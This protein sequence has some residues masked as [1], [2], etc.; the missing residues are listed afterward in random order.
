MAS[1]ARGV[2]GA[3]LASAALCTP[4]AGFSAV[5]VSTSPKQAVGVAEREGAKEQ[6]EI[7]AGPIAAAGVTYAV[8]TFAAVAMKKLAHRPKTAARVLNK[9]IQVIEWQVDPKTPVPGSEKAC[10]AMVGADVETEGVWDPLGFS[11]LYDR[12]FDFNMVMTYPHVQW[13]RESEIKHGR[14]CMLAFVGVL[15]QQFYQIPGYPAEPDWT[16]ALAACYASKYPT[17][18]VIQISVFTMLVE[19]RWYPDGAW[20]GQMDREPGDLGFDPLNYL[21]RPSSDLKKLQLQELKNGRLAMI[22]LASLASNH[23]IPGSV[24]FLNGLGLYAV[25][26]AEG[27]VGGAGLCG[28]TRVAGRMAV[29]PA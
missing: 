18:G 8:C 13:L 6:P 12:N 4:V 24:P 7:R 19:G 5:P 26:S 1:L 11:K 17:L 10:A 22:G 28:A 16:K 23:A 25:H 3:A 14:I 15:A 2:P 9:P 27:T 20:I 29:E 21:K